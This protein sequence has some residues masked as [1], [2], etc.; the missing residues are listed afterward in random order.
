MTYNADMGVRV[1]HKVRHGGLSQRKVASHL[2]VSR[3]Y[4][5]DA[6]ARYDEDGSLSAVGNVGTLHRDRRFDPVAS[7][8]LLALIEKNDALTPADY[9]VGLA[10]NLHRYFSADDVWHEMRRLGLTLKTR[11]KQNRRASLQRQLEFRQ[12]M[13]QLYTFNQLVFIDEASF[14]RK[15]GIRSCAATPP[16]YE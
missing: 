12:K 9:V 2:K 1:V 16:A 14:D 13:F 11:T 3:K 15:N 6:L 7:A 4:V 5:A 10:V 8:A